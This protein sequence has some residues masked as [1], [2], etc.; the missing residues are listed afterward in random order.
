M[1]GNQS[2]QKKY[3]C[4]IVG[5]APDHNRIPG[6]DI[7]LDDGQVWKFANTEVEVHHVPGH[8]SGHIFY[9]FKKNNLHL[10]EMLFF[11]WGVEEFLKVPMKR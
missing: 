8:T 1:D 7:L 11:L 10:L 5:F 6:I 3:N 2:L 9:Y 4:K